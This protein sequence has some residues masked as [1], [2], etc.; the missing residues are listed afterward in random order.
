VSKAFIGVMFLSAFLLSCAIPPTF[1]PPLQAPTI[2][3]A[4]GNPSGFYPGRLVDPPQWEYEAVIRDTK[5]AILDIETRISGIRQGQM[6]AGCIGEDVFTCVATLAQSLAVTTDHVYRTTGAEEDILSQKD[7]ITVTGE[8][9]FPKEIGFYAY[10]PGLKYYNPVSSTEAVYFQVQ[11]ADDRKIQQIW[12]ILPRS[13]SRAQTKKEYD[14][15]GIY[16]I[17]SPV[18]STTCPKFEREEFYRFFETSVKTVEIGAESLICGRS[19]WYD[20]VRSIRIR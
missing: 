5:P 7:K 16:E 11:I 18:L 10:V 12:I 14:E 8:V 19:L 15:T 17:V 6:K 13:P 9:I 3:S 1:A 2:K 4:A 20:G